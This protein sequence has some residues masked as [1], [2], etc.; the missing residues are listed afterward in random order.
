MNAL[1]FGLVATAFAQNTGPNRFNLASTNDGA[2]IMYDA[3]RFKDPDYYQKFYT[4]V[5]AASQ[6]NGNYGR[7]FSNIFFIQ[8][9]VN[10]LIV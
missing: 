10:Q 8:L 5:N 3:A 7:L 9:K 2:H 4:N 6:L 1:L